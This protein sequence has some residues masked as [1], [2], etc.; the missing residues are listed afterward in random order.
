MGW[1]IVLYLLPL[2]LGI[3]LMGYL[4]V[5]YVQSA[6]VEP[7]VEQQRSVVIRAEQV[8]SRQFGSMR[9][10]VRLLSSRG[11]IVE[12]KTQGDQTEVADELM[13][14]LVAAG[15]Y[16]EA[17][18]FSTDGREI[19]GVYLDAGR[20]PLKT[21][22]LIAASASRFAS[23]EAFVR[24]E[25]KLYVSPLEYLDPSGTDA[26]SL[27]V[28]HIGTVLGAQPSDTHAILVLTYDAR[29][30]LSQVSQAATGTRKHL[31]LLDNRGELLAASPNAQSLTAM[32]GSTSEANELP[33]ELWQRLQSHPAS[34]GWVWNDA[35][36]SHQKISLAALLGEPQNTVLMAPDDH[37][38]LL[39][40]L[41]SLH[42]KWYVRHVA[43]LGLALT[44]LA[45]A[46]VALFGG[47]L[48]LVE[49]DR[50]RKAAQ[51]GTQHVQL[52]N[53]HIEL[54]L[55]HETLRQTQ[56]SLVKSETMAALGLTVAGVSHELN[57]PIG[58][59]TVTQSAMLRQL[60]QL[61]E[62][63]EQGRLSRRE[64]DKYIASTKEALE[65]IQS[66]MKRASGVISM[67]KTMAVERSS[68]EISVVNLRRLVQSC[69]ELHRLEKIKAEIELRVE[70][71]ADLEIR[72]RPGALGQ[73]ITNLLSNA[74]SHAFR[75]A[76]KGVIVLSASVD[77]NNEQVL[78][79][80]SD[81]G[82][83]M[84]EETQVKVFTPF[85]STRR[86][87]GGTGLGLSICHHLVTDVLSGRID[88]K[89]E[90]GNGSC[91]MVWVPKVL[92]A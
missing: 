32:V 23:S 20:D 26:P 28:F 38:F 76:D 46:A 51:L 82:V 22:D 56:K 21:G 35:I 85:F 75:H 54:K 61:N 69:I 44:L 13:R 53:Q 84:D 72:T 77:A 81:N 86:T 68:Q 24:G 55:A 78:I 19:L 27:P 33:V 49:E 17:R 10:D 89:S 11:P 48:I 37:W 90:H 16:L 34:A 92:S 59:V 83:G 4:A 88:F 58:A 79:K 65:L 80:V 91:F 31:H 63:V 1:R 30:L 18:V 43:E 6:L 45:A 12:L 57:T 9:R 36:W 3:F 42:V 50:R 15:L 66:S 52:Q 73:V 70:I 87:E 25:Q 8:L 62:Q 64:L 47:R 7:V 74:S 40:E 71:P 67:L 39:V 41:P 14:F 29:Q 60:E 5:H 2:V